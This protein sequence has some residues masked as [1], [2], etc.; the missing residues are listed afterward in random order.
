MKRLLLEESENSSFLCTMVS[1]S[2]R[3]PPCLL[4]ANV[5]YCQHHHN[6]YVVFFAAKCEWLLKCAKK[7]NFESKQQCDTSFTMS[8]F[9][10]LLHAFLSL[11][12]PSLI[13]LVLGHNSR[14]QFISLANAHQLFIYRILNCISF[15]ASVVHTYRI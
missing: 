7:T 15:R 8:H 2:C 12:G 1:F 6:F 13:K 5:H 14:L 3:H 10:W 11:P 9:C 4:L